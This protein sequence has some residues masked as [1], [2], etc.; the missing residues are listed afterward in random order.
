MSGTVMD[1]CKIYVFLVSVG[2]LSL[3]TTVGATEYSIPEAVFLDQ[4]FLLDGNTM[5]GS[6]FKYTNSR[7]CTIY[8]D[9]KFETPLSP[10]ATVTF[11]SGNDEDRVFNNDTVE[12][13]DAANA[14]F[15]LTGKWS[16]T[17][18]VRVR[19]H[20]MQNVS[21]DINDRNATNLEVLGDYA[22]QEIVNKTQ[23]I[24]TRDNCRV[25]VTSAGTLL[26]PVEKCAIQLK[27]LSTVA[28]NQVISTDQSGSQV[29]SDG[30]HA[31]FNVVTTCSSGF[32]SIY[33]QEDCEQKPNSA[34][35]R[36]PVG[37]LITWMVLILM[38]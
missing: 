13:F 15:S 20:A 28:G 22:I 36:T 38:L 10:Q 8:F 12:T 1:C 34:V 30:N 5:S 32:F 16:G 33:Y 2:L 18:K 6:V 24:W 35:V 4:G 23:R 25:K 9:F 31:D 17:D 3:H 7:N 27:F 29:T 21:G 19:Y 37:L 26:E 14:Q 11:K